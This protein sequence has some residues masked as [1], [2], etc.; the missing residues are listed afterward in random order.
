[1][2]EIK[3][4]DESLKGDINLPNEPF[5]I[6]GKFV[7]S[8]KNGNWSHEIL[9]YSEKDIR[10]MTFPNEKYDFNDMNNTIFIGAY[11]E[12]KCVGLCILQQAMFKYMYLY[13]LKVN[14]D[15]RKKHI[16]KMLIDK[17]KEVA[18]KEG[19]KGIYT[20]AQD[21]NLGACLFYLKNGFEIGGFDSKLYNFTPQEEKSEIYFYLDIV[22]D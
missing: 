19:Y 8:L 1:M 9:L 22:N 10:Q 7:V 17:A 14:C 6:N 18:L 11:D 3:L 15:Y 4:I 5:L 12:N 13:D 2:I 21:N 20:E 16:G